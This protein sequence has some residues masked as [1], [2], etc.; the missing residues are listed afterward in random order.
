MLK[1][2]TFTFVLLAVVSL[3]LSS[4]KAQT[5]SS[6]QSVVIEEL[7]AQLIQILLQQIA[8][9]QEQIKQLIAQQNL[10]LQQSETSG[11]VEAVNK[12]IE[13]VATGGSAETTKLYIGDMECS[14]RP[15]G[16]YYQLP[17]TIEGQWRGGMYQVKNPEGRVITG[18]YLQNG[19]KIDIAFS[20]SRNSQGTYWV[21]IYNSSPITYRNGF[22]VYAGSPIAEKTGT[23]TL[24]SC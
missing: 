19:T 6:E 8:V 7:K 22:P 15:N 23:F 16:T 13:E 10:A 2:L 5:F 4:V 18:G 12:Q 9:L 3:P 11:A 20:D 14:K 24:P 21:N 1:K 17:I